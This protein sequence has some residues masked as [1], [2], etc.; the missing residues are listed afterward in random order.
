MIYQWENREKS[1]FSGDISTLS[2]NKYILT[3]KIEK[4]GFAGDISICPRAR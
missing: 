4:E 2:E 1:D 3:Q